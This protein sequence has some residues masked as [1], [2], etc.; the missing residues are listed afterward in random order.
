PLTSVQ[1]CAPA[2]RAT[3][4][5]AALSRSIAAI[6]TSSERP[7]TSPCPFAASTT[8]VPSGLL[9]VRWPPG[10]SRSRGTGSSQSSPLSG[11]PPTTPRGNVP[12]ATLWP[13]EERHAEGMERRAQAGER[14]EELPLA[15]VAVGIG[16]AHERERVS[17][18][19]ALGEEVAHAVDRR[20][21]SDEPGIV[22][23]G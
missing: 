1:A 19:A 12:A 20:D 18:P 4:D 6:A 17:R 2:S 10:A 13:A 14:L 16:N 5:A 7:L 15:A 3:R 9:R 11:S 21:A 22:G 8:P 23:E